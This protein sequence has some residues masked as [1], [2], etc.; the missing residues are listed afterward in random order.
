M[1]RPVTGRAAPQDRAESTEGS[2]AP[3]E[4]PIG[5][6]NDFKR[7]PS[8]SE[9]YNNKN[10]DTAI[11]KTCRLR[12][13]GNVIYFPGQRNKRK[14]AGKKNEKRMDNHGMRAV[15]HR[16]GGVY[17]RPEPGRGYAE[18]DDTGRKH[19]FPDRAGDHRGGMDETGK[20]GKIRAAADENRCPFPFQER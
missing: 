12:P 4:R 9:I 16:S 17:C 14:K 10:F 5:S 20:R 19:R 15:D 3:A 7:D 11:R 1:S 13:V 6:R 18:L 2:E 8:P